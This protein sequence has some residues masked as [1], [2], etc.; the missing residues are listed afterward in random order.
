MPGAAASSEHRPGDQ[1]A[2]SASNPAKK[3]SLKVAAVMR[4]RIAWPNHIPASAG[5]N[6]SSEA[7][8]TL[9]SRAPAPSPGQGDGRDDEGEA[10]RL[11][12]FVL[13]EAERLQIGHRRQ[14]EDAGRRG[15]GA[16]H[17]AD[18][19]AEP[20]LGARRR[21][22]WRPSARPV[23]RAQR[24]RC[25]ARRRRAVLGLFQQPG[26]G[27]G[28]TTRVPASIGQSRATIAFSFGPVSCQLLV[29]RL[30]M[31]TAPPLGPAP[32]TAEH[33][34]RDRRKA[35]ADHA[36]DEAGEH[37]GRG[38]EGEAIVWSMILPALSVD[39][40]GSLVAILPGPVASGCYGPRRTNIYCCIC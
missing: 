21:A 9:R 32:S 39:C 6:A 30:G 36:L 34:D 12:Q 28:A 14:H 25:R 17:D 26:A 7:P 5:S 23:H 19:R 11:H 27:P 35:E 1:V 18:Q 4:C 3:Q 8:A 40:V 22:A 31:T 10:E 15:G 20:D 38:D 29:T 16:G 2:H 13:V 24:A 37:E 33:A